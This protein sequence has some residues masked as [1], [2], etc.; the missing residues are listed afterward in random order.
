[1]TLSIAMYQKHSIEYQSFIY[2]PLN[3]Q[4]VLF[5]TIRLLALILNI[6]QFYLTHS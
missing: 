2:T 1:M 5:Q 3:N 6:K 4:T